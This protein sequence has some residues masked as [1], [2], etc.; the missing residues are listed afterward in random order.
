MWSIYEIIHF[1][2]AVVDESAMI[3]LHF[4]VT[5]ML[6]SS[7]NLS[8]WFHCRCILTGGSLKYVKCEINLFLLLI[9]IISDINECKEGTHNCS[10]N[11]VCNN[12]KGSY[13]CTC[14][15]GYEGDGNNCTGI[16][17][18]LTW[19]FCMPSK[20]LQCCFYFSV[21]KW[22]YGL[23]PDY[24]QDRF[25]NRVSNYFLRDSSNKFDVPLHRTNYRKNSFRYSGAVL[26]NGLPPTLRQAESIHIFKS[27]GKE[28]FK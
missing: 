1:W 8:S 6:L 5:Y 21:V 24:L 11:A 4:H 15:P 26:W 17:S 2:T 7:S 16:I 28:F 27:G 3:I 9:Y 22:S 23:A 18:F 12:T 14:K 10:S 20:A 19:S 13:N 25:V